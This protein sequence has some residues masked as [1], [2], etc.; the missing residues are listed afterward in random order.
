M[1]LSICYDIVT[2]VLATGYP[3]CCEAASNNP[4]TVVTVYPLF[5]NSGNTILSIGAVHPLLSWQ[6]TILPCLTILR[7]CL[8]L[9][10][11]Y[12]I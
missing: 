5:F 9:T 11:A 1:I 3:L 2:R 10:P 4:L 6:I 12:P 7:T 8:A